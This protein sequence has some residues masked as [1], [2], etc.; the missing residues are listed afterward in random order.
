[1][2]D[3]YKILGVGKN[4]SEEEIKK[5]YRRLAHQYHPDKTGGT[6][7][8]FKEINEAYQVLSNKEKR[9]QY[10]RFGRVFEGA[11]GG[12]PGWEGFGGFP[13]GFGNGGF[14][15]NVNMGEGMGDLGDIF[16]SLFEQFGGA[17]R[18]PTYTRGSDIQVAEELT[19]E[20]AFR[21]VKKKLH[22][23]TFVQCDTC[24]GTGY[25]KEKGLSMCATCQGKGEIREQR[26][27]F[28]GNFAQVK[29]CPTCHGRGQVPKEPCRMC[30]GAGR[31]ESM[32]EVEV[33]IAPGVED[34]Q[35][36]KITGMGEAGEYGSASGDLYVVVKVKPHA[37]FERKG[38]DLFMVKDVKFSEALL[39]KPVELR[40]L[41]GGRFTVKIPTGFDLKDKLKIQGRGMPRFGS[42]ASFLGRGDL[43]LTLSVKVPKT[44]S[45]KAK[46]LLEDLD[47]E[48]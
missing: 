29:T 9:M 32:R 39:G 6:D 42:A 15:W 25:T 14:E 36:I 47:R 24:K 8:K 46:R 44:L 26:R 27:T 28:F 35:I 18:R 21:G 17:R 48:L 20:E 37:A 12:Q 19:L 31:T 45:A 38:S 33:Q 4:A 11:V 30:K 10:D 43:Y 2:K 1:M 5:A 22:F 7:Q 40:D 3:Y 16:E 34:G 13:G 23:R 41:D